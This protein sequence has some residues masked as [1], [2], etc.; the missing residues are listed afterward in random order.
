MNAIPRPSTF[1]RDLFPESD[2]YR[3]WG[4]QAPLRTAEPDP[5]WEPF[6]E[7][8]LHCVW[9]DPKL[10]PRDLVSSRG[11]DVRILHPGDWNHTKG[12]DF[13]NAEWTVDGRHYQGDVEIHIRPMDWVHHG[14]TDDPAFA[15]VR[16]HV[17]YDPG[18]LAPGTLPD[19]CAQVSIKDELEKRSHF[20]F[21]SV[22]LSAYPWDRDGTANGLRKWFDDQS[23]ETCGKWL[24]AAGQERLRRKTQRMSRL[25]RSVG[26]REALYQG[27][28]RGLGYHRNA[29]PA[30]EL[31]RALPLA[32]LARH[33]DGD[34]VRAYAL[35]NGCAGLLPED[36]TPT[37][38]PDWFSLRALWDVWWRNR[39]TFDAIRLLPE[40]WRMD[41]CR[42]G[43]LPSRRFWAAAVWHLR[44]ENWSPKNE[45]TDEV[46]KHRLFQEL[47]VPSPA[48]DEE[49][50]IVGPERAAALFINAVLPWRF[51]VGAT[52]PSKNLLH[53]LPSEP[54][55][56]R[57]RRAAHRFLGPDRHP[58][59]YRGGLRRQGLLQ[60]AEDY[61]A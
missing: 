3:T 13:L 20:F 9:F 49:A 51:C 16:L 14:H 53:K 35:L 38:F 33:A 50:R 11:E 44:L 1:L 6:T 39:E 60:L 10:R 18:E 26:P 24:E 32:Q 30:E 57:T 8:H 22:D 7:R 56:S 48:T 23:D 19:G 43:N 5:D 34:P 4:V 21:E 2:Q 40:R 41:G 58:R 37:R 52:S 59:I 36:A 61:G 54:M 15:R 45:E 25:I 17:T 47:R 42:P 28:M 27:L 12:P 29:D 55:N 46:W 31:A